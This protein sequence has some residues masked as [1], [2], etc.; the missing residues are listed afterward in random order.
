MQVKVVRFYL[1]EDS[2]HLKQI[3]DYLHD[4][5]VMGATMFRG[6][7]GFGSSGKLREARL[8]DIHFDLPIVIEFVEEPAKADEI[9]NHF[10]TLVEGNRILSWTAE[11]GV[12]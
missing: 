10:S 3:Y 1:S 11:M 6:V 7:K 2:P 9:L 8:L 12:S 5:Q 4:Q